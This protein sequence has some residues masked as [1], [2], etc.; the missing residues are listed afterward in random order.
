MPDKLS[1]VELVERLKIVREHV[2]Y[3]AAAA[4]LG[5]GERVLKSNVAEARARGITADTVIKDDVGR[6]TH[7][8]KTAQATIKR[9]TREN[10]EAEMVR[11]KLFGLAARSPEPP[12]WTSAPGRT[13]SR[14]CPV[15]IW[16]DW[17]WGEVVK[18]NEVGGM[19]E[20]NAS[21]ATTRAKRLV[22][23]T[24][25]LAYNHMGRAKANYPGV[26]VCL[27]GDMITG[28]IHEELTATNDRTPQQSI[29]DL[30]DVLAAGLDA[31]ATRFGRLFVPCVVGNHGRSTR[32]PRMKGRVYCLDAE[33]KILTRDLE[34]VPARNLLVGSEIL[35]FDEEMSGPRGRCYR[36]A[37]ITH[38]T[39]VE[40]E[41]IR[42]Q[43]RSGQIFYAT[44]EH[45]FLA[46]GKQ[47]NS[48]VQWISAQE[49]LDQ[50]TGHR[51]NKALWTIDRYL[52]TWQPNYSRDAGY[53]AGVFDGEGTL[54]CK[55]RPNGQVRA[56]LCVTQYPNACLMETKRCLANLDF[57]YNETI[58]QNQL[59]KPCH[60]L[61]LRGGLQEVLR[62][63]G[64]VRPV[65][66]LEK[67]AK[68]DTDRRHMTKIMSDDIMSVSPG[69][70]RDVA[71][72]S[73][74]SGTYISEGYA[75]HNTNFEW[76][77]YC[78]L[79]RHFAKS[80][81]VQFL[82]PGETDAYFSVFGHRY[83][84]THGDSLGVKGGDGIIGAMGP[85][86]RGAIKVGRS[87]AQIGRD[88]DT[89]IMGHWHQYLTFPGVIVNN[90]LKGYD[91]YARLA[92][93]APY[94]R[95]SQALWF[96]H[97]E[98]GITAH[99][100]VFLEGL[101]KADTSNEWVKWQKEKSA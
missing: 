26:V 91:E 46:H 28:D 53:L 56:Q 3:A 36:P 85:I 84:L 82:I 7:E 79:E 49:M 62:F 54:A 67:W 69:G 10:V 47:G 78:N 14:G 11:E 60:Y 101:K 8:L 44:P 5:L 40:T 22:D 27:G 87:E 75:S 39:I 58:V 1:D 65:R 74:D 25:D 99:W 61:T 88:F 95:P 70:K 29:N 80:K 4:A 86:M 83:L 18:A 45:C 21:I 51:K 50:F 20:F 64:E 96:T 76:L 42:I 31:M 23:V 35:G 73:S 38:A 48:K 16:S 13:G 63:L 93:R 77:I 72:L 59:D 24:I 52:N 41:T 68:F 98:H 43:L 81:H 37:T 34:W 32:K 55:L 97:P 15:T 90:S 71:M 30:T 89:I 94:S 17:H 9:L 12:K 2:T 33:T 66:L 100:Q 6:L 19:N 57:T 92:L